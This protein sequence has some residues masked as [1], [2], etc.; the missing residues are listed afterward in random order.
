M[1]ESIIV[2][3]DP[4]DLYPEHSHKC[5]PRCTKCGKQYKQCNDG[6]FNEDSSQQSTQENIAPSSQQVNPPAVEPEK[7]FQCRKC[8]ER[9]VR[10]HHLRK[11]KYT[12]TEDRVYKCSECDRGFTKESTLK[13]HMQK[14]DLTSR[15]CKVCSRIC[16][17]PALLRAHMLTHTGVRDYPCKAC[18]KEFKTLSAMKRHLLFVHTELSDTPVDKRKYKKYYPCPECNKQTSDLK[19]HMML[20][21][22]EK[23]FQCTVCERRFFTK[24]QKDRHMYTHTDEKNT[25]VPCVENYLNPSTTLRR[26]CIT[27]RKD[28]LNV[29]CAI[30]RLRKVIV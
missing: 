16:R 7:P 23:N 14:H 19:Q 27:I 25:R 20:H 21:T 8:G 11:H 29:P 5:D 10:P 28:T 3:C 2:V 18:G 30:K 12:H 17:N 15:Q 13:Q 4:R 24:S 26:T 6:Q 1:F 22:G 9:F